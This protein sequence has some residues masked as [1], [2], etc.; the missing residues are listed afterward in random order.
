MPSSLLYRGEGLGDAIA[1]PLLLERKHGEKVADV[2]TLIAK[3]K[4]VGAI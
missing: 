4:S 3:L 1:I 2:D